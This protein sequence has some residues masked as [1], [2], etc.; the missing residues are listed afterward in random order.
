VSTNNNTPN[1]TPKRPNGAASDENDEEN[2]T[3]TANA[4][5]AA[6]TIR[7]ARAKRGHQ[8]RNP[9]LQEKIVAA[10]EE[11]RAREFAEHPNREELNV[12]QTPFGEFLVDYMSKQRP[13][14]WTTGR[15]ARALGLQRFTINNWVY[16]GKNPPI[17]TIL[18]IMAQLNAPLTD[19]LAIYRKRG[20]AVP[21]L[22]GPEEA[23]AIAAERATPGAGATSA[24]ATAAQEAAA[25]AQ[26]RAERM[27]EREAREWAEMIAQTRRSMEIGGF[28]EAMI[29]M[30]IA[31]IEAKRDNIDPMARHIQAEHAA[32]VTPSD[33]SMS[34]LSHYDYDE[35]SEAQQYG[36]P[37]T[38]TNTEGAG[39]TQ[40]TT[41]SG[42]GPL[43]GEP[44][45]RHGSNPKNR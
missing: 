1:N 17:E 40:A 22:M 31:T 29:A 14:V 30:T 19:L 6:R 10:M 7:S 8:N 44:H 27:R 23:A 9:S 41:G 28:P 4:A 42:S 11:N 13:R 35:R 3:D 25:Q 2:E 20:V 32:P 43:N 45:E 12:N 34:R 26:A 21:N 37:T 15:L 36:P 18:T 16:R 24:A 33:A 39:G 5:A 38:R